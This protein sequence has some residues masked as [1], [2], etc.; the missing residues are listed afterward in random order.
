MRR[1]PGAGLAAGLRA[2]EVLRRAPGRRRGRRGLRPVPRG[3]TWACSAAGAAPSAWSTAVEQDRLLRAWGDVLNGWCVDDE[4]ILR[5]QVLERTLPEDGDALAAYLERAAAV[6]EDSPA[7]RL[8]P[9]AA[10]RRP[11]P[12][13]APR[14]VPRACRCRSRR[15][16]S[17]AAEAATSAPAKPWPR[18]WST[19]P[20]GPGRPRWS[21]RGY[22][23][24]PRWCAAC[25]PASIPRSPSAPGAWL[26]GP[27]RPA[28]LGDAWPGEVDHH[29]VALPGRRRLP[30][31]LLGGGVAPDPRG[32]RLPRPAVSA[33]QVQPDPQHRGRAGLAG[34][35]GP[36]GPRRPDRLPGRP[37]SC[38]TGPGTC[39][40]TFRQMEGEA[41]AR[42]EADL[43]AGHGEY[44]FSAYVTVSAPDPDTLETAATER[45][46]P[47]HP[48]AGCGCGASTAS[49]TWASPAPCRWPGGCGERR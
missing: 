1:R 37:G 49:R 18:S 31:H 28:R 48:A 35:G 20:S 3:P 14:D 4:S 45:R 5:L 24:R 46:A 39:R 34:A 36:G 17:G 16:R 22:S 42:R 30:R 27:D 12:Q 10:G 15:R 33:E 21:S 11:A 43:A 32:R 41:L 7:A 2:P 38:G 13:P 25:G 23:G 26:P 40:R 29:V 19:W 8:L 6:P 9:A 47:G 44:R